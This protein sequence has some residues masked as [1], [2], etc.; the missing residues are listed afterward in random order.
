ME[1][2]HFQRVSFLQPVQIQ[3]ASGTFESQCLDISLKGI[4]LV[5]PEGSNWQPGDELTVT[6]VLSELESIDMICTLV[7]C[8]GD[9]MGCQCDSL[10]LDSMTALRRLLE[11]NLQ[12]PEE[13]HR[14]LADLIHA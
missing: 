3:H 6:L 12:D 9:V 11:L 5:C 13:V 4:L 10:D 7:H 2:R 1:K 14:E 8:H